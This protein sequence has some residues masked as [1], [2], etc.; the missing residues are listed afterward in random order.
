MI[1]QLCTYGT[2]V[3]QNI[4]ICRCL[5]D[6]LFDSAVADLL[7]PDKLQLY[8]AQHCPILQYQI[9]RLKSPIQIL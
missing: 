3:L 4:V 5:S 1:R 7:T 8:L 6:Q 2:Q 9:S